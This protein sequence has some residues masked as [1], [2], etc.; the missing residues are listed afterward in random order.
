MSVEKPNIQI[1]QGFAPLVYLSQFSLGL[2][3]QV[4]VDLGHQLV[5]VG[6]VDHAGLSDGLAAGS[7]A[8][9]AV[10]TDL[11]EVLGGLDIVIQDITDQSVF[12]NRS[13]VYIPPKEVFSLIKILYIECRSIS[14]INFK[15][16]RAKRTPCFHGVLHYAQCVRNLGLLAHLSEALGAVDGTI[17]LGLEG[18]LG[19]LTASSAGGGEELTGATG[20]LLTSVTAALAA[21]GLVLEAALSVELLLAGGENEFVAA[22]FAH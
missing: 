8:A 17:S 10:H 13:H 2:L 15:E 18:N 3:S 20:S 6:A 11:E 12:G 9:Q 1:N 4:G 14:T 7:G 22:L 21:L 16:K 5:G 19:F